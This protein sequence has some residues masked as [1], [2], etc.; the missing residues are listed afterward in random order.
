MAK[1]AKKAPSKP[2]ARAKKPAPKKSAPRKAA[3]PAAPKTARPAAPKAAA[4]PKWKPAGVHDMIANLVL[5]NA[6]GAIEFYKNAFGAKEQ[7]R[8]M[9]P[10]GTGV[11]HAELR[12]GDSTLF[13]NDEMPGGPGFVA[14]PGPGQKPTAT[15]QIY[16]ADCDAVFTRAVR[17]G[18]KPVMPMTDMFW[19]DRM[20]EVIDP[21]GQPW[22]ISTRMKNLSD[23]EMRKGGEEFAARMS[24][25]GGMQQPPAAPQPASSTAP[26]RA[27][28]AD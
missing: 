15:L 16:V 10:D 9:S 27:D 2:K 1:K 25:Q 19:G 5:K 13:L 6:A 14:A 21:F 26:P 23:A 24:Q 11:W 8:M 17:A 22:M 7:R 3:R 20:G 4:Q 12:I 28:G 18:A